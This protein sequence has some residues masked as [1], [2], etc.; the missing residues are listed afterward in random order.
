MGVSNPVRIV[1]MTLPGA[2]NQ[3]W[4]TSSDTKAGK[5]SAWVCTEI[6]RSLPSRETV[7]LCQ[8]K[9]SN[10]PGAFDRSAG[11][12]EIQ[13]S[14]WERSTSNGKCSVSSPDASESTL[15]SPNTL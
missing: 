5:S 12:A 10:R 2:E 15:D 1:S 13:R 7:Q 9:K 11:N 4:I 6:V 8:L 14:T 3:S